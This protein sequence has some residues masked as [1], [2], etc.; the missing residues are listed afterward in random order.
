MRARS[1]KR[2]PRTHI[3]PGAQKRMNVTKTVRKVPI[4][5]ELNKAGVAIDDDKAT[6]KQGGPKYDAEDT[7]VSGRSGQRPCRLQQLQQLEGVKWHSRRLQA[8]AAGC[9]HRRLAARRSP[10]KKPFPT[11]QPL[12][13][14][15]V[16]ARSTTT[17][18]SASRCRTRTS[19]PPCR[20]SARWVAAGAMGA[21]CGEGPSRAGGCEQCVRPWLW[22]A[23]GVRWQ[24]QPAKLMQRVADAAGYPITMINFFAPW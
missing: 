5:L 15:A 8:S 23:C 21:G 19:L 4:D 20:V 14:N 3:L 9:K 13:P 17:S 1:R 22:A 6:H 7:W 24:T 10:Y 2:A 16:A 12:A 11:S 18:T